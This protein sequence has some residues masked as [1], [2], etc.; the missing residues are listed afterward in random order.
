MKVMPIVLATLALLSAVVQAQT[1]QT[2]PAKIIVHADH[3]LGPVNPLVF[4]QNIEAGIPKASLAASLIRLSF[5]PATA[6]GMTRRI[7]RTQAPLPE[8]EA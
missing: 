6:S 2:R 3:V 7:A 8:P 1:P 5:R 4:G